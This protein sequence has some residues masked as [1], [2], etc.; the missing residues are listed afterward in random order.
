MNH[1]FLQ[2]IEEADPHV[3]RDLGQRKPPRP[4]VASQQK[5]STDN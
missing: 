2:R 4:V 3:E 5:C 1:H